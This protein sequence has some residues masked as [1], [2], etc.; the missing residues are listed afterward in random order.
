MLKLESLQ[1]HKF[2]P[3][4][5]QQKNDQSNISHV[6]IYIYIYDKLIKFYHTQVE[7]PVYANASLI[8]G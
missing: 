3:F 2:D 6:C 5:E 1:F 7:I 4:P 8:M